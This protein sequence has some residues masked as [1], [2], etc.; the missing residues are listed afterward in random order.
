MAHSARSADRV[1]YE[2][3]S[4][5]RASG[6]RPLAASGSAEN[7]GKM[8]GCMNALCGLRISPRGPAGDGGYA[9]Y[10]GSGGTNTAVQTEEPRSN[11]ATALPSLALPLTDAA[12]PRWIPRRHWHEQWHEQ[13]E[14]HEDKGPTDVPTREKPPRRARRPP[15]RE[16]SGVPSSA[17][18]FDE[19]KA[20]LMDDR[21]TQLKS[22]VAE[23]MTCLL[24]TSDAADERIV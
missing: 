4:P 20:K 17:P 13:H 3:N 10:D 22:R 2:E 16:G 9:P 15:P 7:T 8:D 1:R 14:Q 19:W 18:T 24:Y 6:P 11:E 5:L 12:N 23:L 21:V